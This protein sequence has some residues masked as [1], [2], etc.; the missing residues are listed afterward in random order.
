MAKSLPLSLILKRHSLP[1]LVTFASVVVTSIIYLATTSP[2]YETAV[3]MMID[4]RRVSISELGQALS[5]FPDAPSGGA[6][7]IATQAEL[8]KSQR[9]LNRALAI[10]FPPGKNDLKPLL[11]PGELSGD[12]QVKIVPAT[13]ILKLSYQNPDPKLAAR[14]INAIA[15]AMVQ[16]NAESIRLEA[17]SVRKFLETRVPQQRRRLEEVEALESRYRQSSGLVSADTQ[18]SSLVQSLATVEDQERTSIAQLQEARTRDSLLQRVTGVAALQN[19]YAAARVG[20]DEGLTDLRS[21]LAELESKVVDARSRLGDQ[22]PDLLALQQQRDEMRTLYAQRLAR[23]LGQNQA[24]PAGAEAADAASRDLISKYIVG[25]VERTALE[26]KL[27]AIEADRANLQARIAELPAKQQRLTILVRQREEEEA[28]LKLLQ[29]KLEQARIA[30]AQLVSN[31]RVIDVAEDPTTPAVPKLPVVVLMA[32]V[33]GIILAIAMVLLLELMNNTI[34]SAAEA[35]AVLKLPVLGTLPKVPMVRNFEQL[36][37]FLDNPSLIEPYRM[38]L[39]TLELRSNNQHKVILVSSIVSG[40]GKSNVIARLAAVA[41][42]L[43]RRTLVIDADL[44]QP[45]Q[46]SFFNLPAHPGLTDIVLGSDR[47]A[48]G[49]QR[50]A[51]ERLTV[52]PHGQL[53]ARPSMA[54]EAA[55]MRALITDAA[56][57]YDLVLIDVSPASHWADAITLSP[58]ADGLILVIRPEFTPREIALRTLSDLQGSGVSVLGLVS[59]ATPDPVTKSSTDRVGLDRPPSAPERSTPLGTPAMNSRPEPSSFSENTSL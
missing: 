28:A 35:E 44:H 50:T 57:H 1:A 45:L 53:P 17:S 22:H 12:L 15:E 34:R 41:A 7:P 11:T 47:L 39:K 43:S 30:E 9:V 16:E 59:N 6:N 8:V 55:A 49:A 27:R 13:N 36:E 23:V 2:R 42:M 5:E 24:V 21:R 38:L 46:N 19:A 33:A 37:R 14:L 54:L 31:V 25:E 58:Y 40:E 32:I 52:L 20:Q 29:S 56:A 18:T 51:L 4:E 3:R 48:T 10:A 26:S